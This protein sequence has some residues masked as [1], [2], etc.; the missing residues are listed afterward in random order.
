MD[1]VLLSNIGS[2]ILCQYLLPSSPSISQIRSHL[3]RVHE[4]VALGSYLN[5]L[6]VFECVPFIFSHFTAFLD[7]HVAINSLGLRDHL[8][9]PQ[10]CVTGLRAV[11]T[12]HPNSGDSVASGPTSEKTQ[13]PQFFHMCSR[14][15][16]DADER[17]SVTVSAGTGGI[18]HLEAECL[19][20]SCGREP[21]E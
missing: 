2:Q 5:C 14:Q 21:K 3:H 4:K 10:Y 13:P 16:P 15:F 17:V 11:T 8:C 19:S 20:V 18:C 6:L 9:L 7:K 12:L 1:R